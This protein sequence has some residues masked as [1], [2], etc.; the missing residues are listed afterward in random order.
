MYVRKRFAVAAATTSLVG[1]LSA[2][3]LAA[4]ATA[5]PSQL[6]TE[7]AGMATAGS[8]AS[9]ESVRAA[10]SS[11]CPRHTLC[12]FTGKNYGGRMLK[13]KDEGGWQNL[14]KY[15]ADEKI[16][17]YHNRRNKGAKFS[18]W[19]GGGGTVWNISRGGMSRETGSM[20]I[21]SVYLNR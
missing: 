11:G 21:K 18:R 7:S 13:F 14:D 5:V 20:K 17:S 2:G 4:P 1:G 8:A 15:G 9:A 16:K 10:A 6:P 12:V 19:N 3:L